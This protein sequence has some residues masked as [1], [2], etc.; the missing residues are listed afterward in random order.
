MTEESK[1]NLDSKISYKKAAD[2]WS[3]VDPTIDCM[4]GGFG[5]FLN[6]Y[7][8]MLRRIYLWLLI[9]GF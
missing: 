5:V 7:H 6:I 3:G 8:I 4:L 1:E 9:C 2:Y